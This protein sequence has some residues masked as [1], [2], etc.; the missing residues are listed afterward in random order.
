LIQ[1]G[2]EKS[3]TAVSGKGASAGR[4]LLSQY[5][6]KKGP[7]KKNVKADQDQKKK[8]KADRGG[9]Q[10]SK[11]A[12]AP[13]GLAHG[14]TAALKRRRE[15]KDFCDSRVEP[16]VNGRRGGGIPFYEKD[17]QCRERGETLTL[18]RK[19]YIR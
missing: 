2:G 3:P 15:R 1:G 11:R 9:R 14:K 16:F 19:N 6:K 18:A 10:V 7:R 13:A 4:K 8:K 17:E 5:Q 12:R